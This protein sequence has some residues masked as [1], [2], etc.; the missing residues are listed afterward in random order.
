MELRTFKYYDDKKRRLSIFAEKQE[1]NNLCITIIPCSRKDVFKKQISIDLFNNISLG[2]VEN[3]SF[4]QVVIPIIENKPGKT[5]IDWCEHHCYKSRRL[6]GVFHREVLTNKNNNN[7]VPLST[8]K[9]S[10]IK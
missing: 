4:Y 3:K 5:F 10:H 7:L 6:Y 1:D 2:K 9:K 8:W